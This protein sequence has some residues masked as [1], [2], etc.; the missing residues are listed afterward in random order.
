[1]RLNTAKIMNKVWTKELLFDIL[2]MFNTIW[3]ENDMSNKYNEKQRDSDCRAPVLPSPMQSPTRTKYALLC[4]SNALFA[5][6][7]SGE[8]G[9]GRRFFV[10][11]GE[12]AGGREA[13]CGLAAGV[14]FGLQCAG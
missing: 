12:H 4:E 10:N 3:Q 6:F 1:M 2:I 5:V 7:L 9:G 13:A 14:S 11:E 8:E